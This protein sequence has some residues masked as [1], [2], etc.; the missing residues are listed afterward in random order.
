MSARRRLPRS[1]DPLPGE[2]LT[3]FVLRLA[4]RLEVSPQQITKAT[5]LRTSSP[6]PI[7]PA[8]HAV[9]LAPEVAAAF[10]HATRLSPAEVAE[11][12]LSSFGHRYFAYQAYIE[13]WVPSAQPHWAAP[14]GWGSHRLTRYCPQCLATDASPIQNLHGGPWRK[15][16]H[17]PVS[18]ACVEHER[19]LETSCPHCR[20]PI[21][22]HHSNILIVRPALD[23]LHPAQCRN[24][25][26][27]ADRSA[28]HEVCAGRLDQPTP[29]TPVSADQLEC[30]QFLN[31]LLTSP[32]PQ[33]Q[34]LG[35]TVAPL[36]Y[37]HD[38]HA[39]TVLLRPQ[40]APTVTGQPR[41]RLTRLPQVPT[42]AA[43]V[44]SQ[45]HHLLALDGDH[46]ERAIDELLASVRWSPS[47]W[48]A[49]LNC[50][51]DSSSTLQRLIRR[52][53]ALPRPVPPPRR[54]PI[55][56]RDRTIL[57][58][59]HVTFTSRHIP[60]HLPA[61]WLEQH[62]DVP[63]HTH[64]ALRHAVP[65]YLVQM[66]AGGTQRQCAER[67]DLTWTTA[68][69][70]LHEAHRRVTTA[71]VTDKVT[72]GLRQLADH[73]DRASQH[74]DYHHRRHTLAS[75]ELPDA[76][77][78]HLAA[79][80][81]PPTSRRF[82]SSLYRDSAAVLIWTQVTQSHPRRAPIVQR[83]QATS[84]RRSPL[85][86]LLAETLYRQR[87]DQPRYLRPIESSLASYARALAQ[88]L[89]NQRTAG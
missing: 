84:G 35:R 17:L 7:T 19:L 64:Q 75:W 33:A 21:N 25:A 10:A 9:H 32:T 62:F 34:S 77:W 82:D 24:P 56:I 47:R 5:G 13:R 88:N 67:L 8:H 18:F 49:V 76:D 31:T 69:S 51:R 38:L 72:A 60:Q 54:M 71:R 52:A 30:Q 61:A 23:L 4:H 57:P 79:P 55:P 48:S 83:S 53:D 46:G 87:T 1:L 78:Q 70:L 36:T 80:L 12:C 15:L 86:V 37:F 27:D 26:T 58:S 11:L 43:R 89:D 42:D 65:I 3:G 63:S 28:R 66:I 44:L 14:A 59:H 2:S 16:W 39:A 81:P 20:K 22:H 85:Q 45:A 29:S 41:R 68:Q 74:V 40:P 73:L 6:Q 50:A